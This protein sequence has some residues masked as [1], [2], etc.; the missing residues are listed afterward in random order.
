[1]NRIVYQLKTA[2]ISPLSLADAKTYLKVSSNL[3]DDLIQSLIDTATEWGQKYTGREFTNNTWLALMNCFTDRINLRRD[4]VDVINSITYLVSAVI[5]TVATDTHYLVKNNQTSDIVLEEGK[6]WP[7][8]G[9]SK[10]NSYVVDFTTKEYYCTNEILTSL[11]RHVSYM[12]SNRGDC[13][14]KSAAQSSGVDLIYN[15]FRITRI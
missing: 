2:G 1:M 10:E 6:Q 14:T 12:Y 11:Q 15:Q 7:T 8:N 3:D 5:T 13:D 4:P 9:D